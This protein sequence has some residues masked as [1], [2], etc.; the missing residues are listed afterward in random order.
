MALC[1]LL[2]T[3]G[4]ATESAVPASDVTEFDSAGVR[5][6]EQLRFDVPRVIPGDPAP[7]TH[8]GWT[9]LEADDLTTAATPG[10][11]RQ[12]R[13]M[14]EELPRPAHEPF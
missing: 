2:C 9:K 14:Y 3:A 5:V 7:L 12:V 1:A 11:R 4:C 6:V 13:E 10:R 8:E